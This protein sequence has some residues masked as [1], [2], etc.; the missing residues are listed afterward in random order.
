[1]QSIGY[2]TC[3]FCGA[4]NGLV[5]NN[6]AVDEVRICRACVVKSGGETV[7]RAIFDPDHLRH[8]TTWAGIC[9]GRRCNG[10][11]ARPEIARDGRHRLVPLTV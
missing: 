4:V 6:D 5:A 9:R 7:A 3:D 1:M 8:R 10:I 2:G 11:P